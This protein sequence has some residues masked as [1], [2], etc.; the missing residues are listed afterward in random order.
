MNKR[1]VIQYF[2]SQEKVSE[3]IGKTRP[4]VTM[5]PDPIP[6]KWALFLDKRTDL[7]FNKEAYQ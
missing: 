3:F 6:V 5:W 7:E 1:E 2:G 4:A